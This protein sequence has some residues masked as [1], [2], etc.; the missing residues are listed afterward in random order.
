MFSKYR[1]K[2]CFLYV[3]QV[4]TSKAGKLMDG[5]RLKDAAYSE[6][7]NDQLVLWNVSFQQYCFTQFLE[8][9]VVT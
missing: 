9:C 6:M 5:D 2:P 7:S 3:W 8:T 1:I 4:S